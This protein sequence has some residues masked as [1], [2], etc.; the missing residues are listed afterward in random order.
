MAAEKEATAVLKAALCVQQ[1][2]CERGREASLAR[3]YQAAFGFLPNP[4]L[5]HLAFD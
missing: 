1:A 3:I 4:L 5:Q 2:L